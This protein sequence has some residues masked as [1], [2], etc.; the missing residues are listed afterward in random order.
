MRVF[1][2]DAMMLFIEMGHH[3]DNYYMFNCRWLWNFF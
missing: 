1:F 2:I 3:C